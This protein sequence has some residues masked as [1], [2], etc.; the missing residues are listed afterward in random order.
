M[1]A[2]QTDQPEARRFVTIA[3]QHV[4]TTVIRE[5][6]CFDRQGTFIC[7]LMLSGNP[8]RYAWD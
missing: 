3:L 7:R 8:I 6:A 2:L 5:Q 4:T 1:L